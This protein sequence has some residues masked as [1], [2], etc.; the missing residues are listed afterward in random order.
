MPITE[1]VRILAVAEGGG[2]RFELLHDVDGRMRADEAT[3]GWPRFFV[4]EVRAGRLVAVHG[5]YD[6][7]DDAVAEAEG[8]GAGGFRPA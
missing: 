6:A 3:V 4:R 1:I 2:A 8:R 7:E 5:P